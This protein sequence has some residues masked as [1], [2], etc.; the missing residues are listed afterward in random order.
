MSEAGIYALTKA[1]LGGVSALMTGPFGSLDLPPGSLEDA[2]TASGTGMVIELVSETGEPLGRVD[3]SNGWSPG[4]SLLHPAF[5]PGLIATEDARFHEHPGVDPFAILTALSDRGGGRIRG[6][7]SLT[8]QAVKNEILGNSR[9]LE[10]KILEGVVSVRAVHGLGRDRILD[11]YLAKSW[12]GRGVF[13]TVGASRAWFGKTWD[14]LSVSETALLIG[15]LK[16]PARY[17]PARNPEAATL[18][19]DAV[20]GRML[21]GGVIT[22]AEAETARAEPAIARGGDLSVATDPWI[23]AAV[24]R[25]LETGELP[26][27]DTARA[28][29]TISPDWQHLVQEAVSWGANRIDGT[30]PSGTLSPDLVSSGDPDRIRAAMAPLVDTNAQIGR[31]LVTGTSPLSVLIDRGYGPLEPETLVSGP[32]TARVGEVY[33]YRR[34]GEGVEL[35]PAPRV[36][37]A[38]VVM[39]ARTG[40]ILAV[41][42][43]ANPEMSRFDRSVA[44]R[45][46]GSAIKPFLWA[47]ALEAGYRHDDLVADLNTSYRTPTG[48]IWSPRNYDGSETGLIPLFVALEESSNN[49]AAQLIDQLGPVALAEITEAAGVYPPGGM[50]LHPSSALGASESTL[51][52]MV[53]G[54]ASIANGGVRV[55]PHTHLMIESGGSLLIPE[56]P[57]EVPVMTE[58]TA[59]LLSSMLY[60]VTVRGTAAGAF[61]QDPPIGGKTGTTQS[62]R[63]AWFVGFGPDLVIGVWVGRD[64]NAPLPGRATGA[65]AAAPIVARIIEAADRSGLT[66]RF[67]RPGEGSDWPPA[68]LASGQAPTQVIPESGALVFEPD[69]DA[70]RRAMEAGSDPFKNPQDLFDRIRSQPEEVAPEPQGG[71]TGAQDPFS[72]GTST[73]PWS[74]RPPVDPFNAFSSN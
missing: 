65:S 30:G 17:D 59:S 42:G 8:Q 28:S 5:V 66:S 14:Q 69:P 49:V 33:A 44:E 21:S 72:T 38:A 3:N 39:E 13:G 29:L 64:G 74:E 36:N 9:T 27:S 45:Q 2:L 68:L 6:G 52:A 25:E 56:Q 63:D 23:T 12:F 37:A 32:D 11:G 1:I 71:A 54:Y 24:L 48:E 15:L 46:V 10:R 67:I 50:S 19:R 58:G 26:P 60:G 51:V 61:G 57:R 7:S 40:A 47:R 31:A 4:A 70:R 34:G 22:S 18:R 16:G 55:T 41:V 62:H 20:L 35:L 73:D 53:A 43:G